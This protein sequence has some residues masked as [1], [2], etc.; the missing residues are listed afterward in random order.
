MVAL[1]LWISLSVCVCVCVCLLVTFVY[2]EKTKHNT[3]TVGRNYKYRG[4]PHLKGHVTIEN[5]LPYYDYRVPVFCC[6]WL[7]RPTHSAN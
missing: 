1:R 7:C 6:T 2:P 5:T 3:F 4:Q